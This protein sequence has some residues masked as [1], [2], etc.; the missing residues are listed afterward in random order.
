MAGR[1]R[2][3]REEREEKPCW[4]KYTPDILLRLAPDILLRL[5]PDIPLRLA[6]YSTTTRARYS[7]TTRI[8][9]TLLASPSCPARSRRSCLWLQ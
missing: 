7:T 4:I 3:R 6:R 9:L 8:L 2:V 5:A 1:R